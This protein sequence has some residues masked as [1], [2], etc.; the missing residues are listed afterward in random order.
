[1]A[2]QTPEVCLQCDT[3]IQEWGEITGIMLHEHS[4]I[5]PQE[6]SNPG[7]NIIIV[8]MMQYKLQ[9]PLPDGFIT[10]LE[11]IV[12]PS[13]VMLTTAV[14][15]QGWCHPRFM[16]H[17]Y[18]QSSQ[19]K[20]SGHMMCND[21]AAHSSTICFACATSCNTTYNLLQWVFPLGRSAV[22]AG[23]FPTV[24]HQRHPCSRPTWTAAQPS[25]GTVQSG[26]LELPAQ[27]TTYLAGWREHRHHSLNMHS[28]TDIKVHCLAIKST[29]DN[30]N[31]Q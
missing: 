7:N 3:R 21:S 4:Q 26:P 24:P 25:S 2:N 23:W 29:L 10:L 30:T 9:F 15:L 27:G 8:F 5:P 13:S 28:V 12:L 17:E 22:G 18:S 20:T 31:K 19:Q 11:T 16:L 14:Q 1:M 6:G